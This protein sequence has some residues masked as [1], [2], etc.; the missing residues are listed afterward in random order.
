TKRCERPCGD[1]QTKA[2]GCTD[3]A[4]TGPNPPGEQHNR[5]WA[6]YELPPMAP[7]QHQP[8]Y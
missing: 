8:R 1:L 3:L 5:R 6:V 4:C 7:P 2:C